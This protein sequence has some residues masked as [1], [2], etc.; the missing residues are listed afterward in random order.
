MASAVSPNFTLTSIYARI[1]FAAFINSGVVISISE[2][3]AISDN[4]PFFSE[5]YYLPAEQLGS[6]LH[7]CIFKRLLS[8]FIIG[9]KVCQSEFVYFHNLFFSLRIFIHRH[10]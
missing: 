7:P 9:Q 1:E 6:P 8:D 3:A 10:R 5:D 4:V 2:R